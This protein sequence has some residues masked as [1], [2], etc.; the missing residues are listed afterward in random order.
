MIVVYPED[1]WY[2]GVTLA[3]AD[4]IFREHLVGGHPVQRLLYRPEKPGANKITRNASVP[5]PGGPR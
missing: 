1:I 4:E 5:D 3:D 2:C